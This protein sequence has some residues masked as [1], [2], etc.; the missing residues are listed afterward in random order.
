MKIIFGLSAILYTSLSFS[1]SVTLPNFKWG[2][3]D[4]AEKSVRKE[5]LFESMKESRVLLND[6]ICSN[7][8]HVWAFDFYK[9]FNIAAGKI[10]LFYTSSN[11]QIDGINWW[12]HTAPIVNE[13]S[14][15]WIMDAGFPKRFNKPLAIQEWLKEFTKEDV[16][17][18]INFSDTDLIEYMFK[19]HVYPQKTQHGQYN[20][21][22]MLT[23]GGYWTPSAIAKNL[24]GHD[25]N[26]SPIQFS[27]DEMD[28]DEVYTACIEASST[29]W[30]EMFG[31]AKRRC[32]NYV[33]I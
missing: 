32:S 14:K 22:Y 31:S 4:L 27:R 5:V 12:Y 23:P 16:C 28:I 29:P 8:A 30:G 1:S 18:E 13:N 7:R 21:Y 2:L 6:S 24:T 10:F 33:S 17:K 11:S 19:Q 20:C 15:V 25:R 26:G 3:E 9:K